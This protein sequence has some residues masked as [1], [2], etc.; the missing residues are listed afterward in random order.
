ME[1]KLRANTARAVVGLSVGGLGALHYAGRH[2]GMFRYAAGFGLVQAA[3][4]AARLRPRTLSHR[5]SL[6]AR[7]G[8]GLLPQV[9]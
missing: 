5:A 2:P 3:G 6:A 9:P 1:R 7:V 4:W 8:A